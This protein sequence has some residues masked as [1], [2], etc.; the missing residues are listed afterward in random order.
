MIEKGYVLNQNSSYYI[1]NNPQIV[2][3]SIENDV[4]KAYYALEGGLTKE[5][6]NLLI[7][8]GYILNFGSP[9][10]LKNNP[11]I[12]RASIEKDINSANYALE[13]GLTEENINLLI[14]KGYVL[15]Y[16]SPEILRC[17]C[18]LVKITLNKYFGS[19]TF[20]DEQIRNNIKNK[21]KLTND[22]FNILNSELPD[23]KKL[24]T[25]LSYFDIPD[26]EL[27]CD[28]VLYILNHL[29]IT[30]EKIKYCADVL[31][32]L[33]STNSSEMISLRTELAK[34]I[35]DTDDPLKNLDKIENL[36]VKNNI[37]VVGKLY[38][39]FDI[40]HPDFNGYDFDNNKVSPIL[41]SSSVQAKKIIVFSDLIKA[42]FGSN[43]KSVNEYL[44]NIEIASNLYENI[45]TGK[46][47][48]NAISEEEKKELITFSKHLATLYDNTMKAKKNNENFILTGNALADIL[49][50]SKKL[51]PGGILDYSLKD[52][53]IRMFCGFAGIDTLEEAQEYINNKIKTAD[54]RNRKASQ[55]DMS[56]DKGDF[57]KGIGDI[58]YL[59]NI[60]QNGS[61]AKDYLGSAADSDMTPLD[62]DLSMV[63]SSDGSISEKRSHLAAREFGP[64]WFV[65][66][67]DDR[68]QITRNNQETLNTKRDLSKIEVFYTGVGGLDYYGIRTGFASSEINYIL[69]DNYDPRVGLT[70]AMNG[71][72]IP[73]ANAEGKIV[74]TPDDY[75][76]LRAKMSGLSY[77]DEQNY[78]FSDNLVTEE[79]KYF[80]E[81][82]DK[83]NR[84]VQIKREKINQVI[85]KALDELGLSLK[86][87]IDGDLTEGFVEFIDTGSTGRGTN[88]PGDG[89]FDFMMRLDRKIMTDPKELEK[90][91]QTILKS[92]GR[93]NS[94]E[95]TGD[96]DFR[97]KNVPLD[98]DTNVDIDITFNIRT[99]KVTYSTD[100]ALRD[101]L[102]T[103][104]KNDPEKYKYVVANILLAKKVLK[105]ANAYKPERSDKSQG[106]LGGVGIEN[107]ILQNGGSF[108]DAAK[109]FV[110][111]ADGKNFEQFKQSYEIWDF[112]D[113]HRAE[114]K[115]EFPNDNFVLNNMSSGGYDRMVGALK[116]YLNKLEVNK[117]SSKTNDTSSMIVDNMIK[118]MESGLIDVDGN[119]IKNQNTYSLSSKTMG[120]SGVLLL[121]FVTTIMCLFILILGV[122]LE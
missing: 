77:Y 13:G 88:K 42:S 84:E 104:Q 59:R 15:K 71:F 47:Q 93:E 121:I 52:R 57:I 35:L 34:Q 18:D 37:P 1:K 108:I 9:E 76:K 46:V 50:L 39:C 54:M 61:I 56:L 72:Y 25:I 94:S 21:Y 98:A 89:D 87:D 66:K 49:E 75:D 33:S 99:D 101:R 113:N 43:N 60:L 30:K 69:M 90:L 79:T 118:A 29:D 36:F 17:N 110:D 83:S 24:V 74:F 103:I 10:T 65:L 112:G 86:T 23:D 2:R 62:T 58:D 91:K 53:V 81:Q 55:M 122:I 100:M 4:N 70:I 105:E 32:K 40:L 14:E 48:Y 119:L 114:K 3:T 44:R 38:S 115:N 63:M 5:N 102:S 45:R 7:E 73:V 92:L 67:N 68:F 11:Q 6:I 26:G 22:A 107:W 41:K 8:K 12:V 19:S 20:L 64:I 117:T 116:K 106:G 95:I 31:Q 97:L 16:D 109:S 96:G 27:Q 111:V 85:K 28:F 82:L 80:A 120:F 51:S 78:A